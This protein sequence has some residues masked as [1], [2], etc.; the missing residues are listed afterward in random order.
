MRPFANNHVQA[1]RGGAGLSASTSV[2]I[3]R[4][5]VQEPPRIFVLEPESHILDVHEDHPGFFSLEVWHKGTAAGKG[6]PLTLEMEVFHGALRSLAQSAVV[7]VSGHARKRL[8]YRGSLPDIN[9]FLAQVE[10]VSDSNYAGEDLL[11]VTVADLEFSVDF[12]M[13]IIINP[14]SDPL[15]LICPPAVDVLEGAQHILIGSNIS[16]QDNEQ[17]PGVYDALVAVTVDMFVSSGRLHL[18]LA[19]EL[20]ETTNLTEATNAINA[21][22]DIVGEMRSLDWTGGVVDPSVATVRFNATL[23]ELRMILAALTF[24]P[25]PRLFYGVVHFGLNVYALASGEQAGCDMAV[26]VHAVNSPPRVSVDSTL[27]TSITGGGM[28]R[29][30]QDLHLAG[31]LRILDPDEENFG[32]WYM[33]R[34]LS[35][36]LNLHASCGAL[37][38]GLLNKAYDYVMGSQRGSIAGVEGLTFHVGDGYFD[39]VLDVTSTIG[40]VNKQLHRLYYHSLD[41]RDTDVTI[42][43]RVD[44]LGN[45]GVGGPQHDNSTLNLR[46][47][48]Q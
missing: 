26:I 19:E 44:D 47:T 8:F 48:M 5:F 25:Y 11:E 6:R 14:V 1:V 21:D 3:Y 10:Y 36:R 13:P 40:N 22:P 32:D 18:K 27:F 28:M 39:A 12:R 34:A 41:C 24:T 30:F 42:D 15:T 16:I 33:Q 23:V 46:V 35:V 9:V 37:S 7:K 43:V 20:P 4:R 2:T 31:V 38:F 45:H 17:L 29:P